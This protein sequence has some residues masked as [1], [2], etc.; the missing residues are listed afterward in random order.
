GPG[1]NRFDTLSA[2]DAWVT[3]GQAPDGIVATH[4]QDNDPTKPVTRTMPLC[5][6]PEQATYDGTGDVNQ[7]SS[8]S[9]APNS[10]L[11]EVG[12]DGEQAGLSSGG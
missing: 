6:F 3:Q 12:P 9:C 4:Y 1:P 8:W 2:L 5:Q 10:K 7:A 11:L